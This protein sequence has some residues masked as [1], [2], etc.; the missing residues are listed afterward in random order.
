MK[1]GKMNVVIKLPI[2]MIPET[3]ELLIFGSFSLYLVN[4]NMKEK[5]YP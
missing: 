2:S 5:I 1:L 3:D 4:V